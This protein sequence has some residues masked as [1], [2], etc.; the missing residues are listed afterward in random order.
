MRKIISIIPKIYFKI[1][2]KWKYFIEDMF[3]MDNF[4]KKD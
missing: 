2:Y 4:K 3:G 1:S